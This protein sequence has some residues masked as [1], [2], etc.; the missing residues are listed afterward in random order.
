[1]TL[2]LTGTSA[3]RRARVR[4]V[5]SRHGETWPR[6]GWLLS[7]E[8]KEGYFILMACATV[9]AVRELQRPINTVFMQWPGRC[10]GKRLS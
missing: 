1:M 5:V 8:L 2:T 9:W 4:F 6:L 10:S 7:F 3:A